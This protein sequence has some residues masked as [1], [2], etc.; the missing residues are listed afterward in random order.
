[1]PS[2]V[3]GK[4]SVAAQTVDENRKYLM[5][6]LQSLVQSS[7]SDSSRYTDLLLCLP[8]LYSIDEDMFENLFC[9]KK[10][11]NGDI[12]ILLKDAVKQVTKNISSM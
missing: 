7:G 10:F 5:K 2:L 11:C 6:Q 3:L 4:P 9:G 12:K 1:M 8:F